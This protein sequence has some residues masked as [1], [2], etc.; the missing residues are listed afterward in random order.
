MSDFFR[1]LSNLCSFQSSSFDLLST[2]TF[3]CW[4]WFLFLLFLFWFSHSLYLCYV[5][6]LDC[7]IFIPNSFSFNLLHYVIL[8][9]W[10]VKSLYS[11]LYLVSKLFESFGFYFRY[12]VLYIFIWCSLILSV[13]GF[14][15][16]FKFLSMSFLYK[17][18][19]EWE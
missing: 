18:T 16:S 15:I 13:L 17:K 3:I 14:Y 2:L 19:H 10:F 5:N 6:F 11:F 9:F 4:I 12:F 7:T 1:K 8:Y